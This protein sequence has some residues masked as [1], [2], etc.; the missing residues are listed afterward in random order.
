MRM[1]GSEE[2]CH[3]GRQWQWGEMVGGS[4]IGENL[5]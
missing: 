1:M 4:D 5:L 2:Q 3:S